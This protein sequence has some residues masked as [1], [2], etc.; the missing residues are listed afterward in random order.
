M[1]NAT[2][3]HEGFRETGALNFNAYLENKRQ[4]SIAFLVKWF[5]CIWIK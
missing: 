4:E 1:N 2:D 5:L 3:H